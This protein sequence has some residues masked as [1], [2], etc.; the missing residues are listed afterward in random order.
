MYAGTNKGGTEAIVAAER[1]VLERRGQIDSGLTVDSVL[2]GFPLTIDR[3]MGEGGLWAPELAAA[4]FIQANGDISEAVHLIRA[5]RS[6]LPRLAFSD[7]MR[8]REVELLRR[9]VSTQRQPDGPII[10]G[11]TVDYTARILHDG[12]DLPLP[13]VEALDDE[14]LQHPADE[15]FRRF[16]DYLADK[17]VLVSRELEED[18]EPFDIQMVAAQLPAHRSAVLSASAQADTGALI[19][20]WYQSVIGPEGYAAENVTLG[21]VRH[22]RIPLRVLDPH[23]GEP[24]DV[25]RIRVSECE[26][27]T[28]LGGE[29][30]EDPTTY[31]VGYAMALGHNERKVIAAASLDVAIVR[32]SGTAVG[33]RLEQVMMHTTD[34]LAA[35]GLLE[36]LQPPQYV[37]S[38]SGLH[39]AMAARAEQEAEL[40]RLL[41]GDRPGD[42]A[43]ATPHDAAAPDRTTAHDSAECDCEFHDHGGQD[44]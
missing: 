12:D 41:A 21:E 38:Q 8:P 7:P 40:V 36:H 4:A 33:K 34:G 6:T 31:D 16:R 9:V 3:I 26:A 42:A 39:A 5:H 24:V 18:E 14:P 29:R 17:G 2:A 10:L 28:H 44:R 15:P 19:N 13:I 20:I 35:S 32:Y 22:G 43:V 11:E 1:L 25:G 30:G 23:T 27:V 37:T